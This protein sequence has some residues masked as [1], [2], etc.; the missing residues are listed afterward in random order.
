MN[1]KVKDCDRPHYGRGYCSKHYQR[2][3]K[4]GNPNIVIDPKRLPDKCVICGE[5]SVWLGLCKTHHGEYMQECKTMK[6]LRE[7]EEEFKD[8][9]EA[10]STDFI[11]RLM[12]LN[13]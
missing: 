10:L 4:H 8:D 9:P 6:I 12:G 7:H 1:C 13:R 11:K 3:R 2:W 5:P